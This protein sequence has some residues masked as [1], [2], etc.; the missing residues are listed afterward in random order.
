MSTMIDNGE[1]T[2]EHVDL[3]D[4]QGW[5]LRG[6]HMNAVRHIAVSV[7]RRDDAKRWI[8]GVVPDIQTAQAW[9]QPPETT[10]NLAFT[11]PGLDALGVDADTMQVFPTEFRDGMAS[12]AMK[13]GDS[14]LSAPEHWIEA[15]RDPDAVHMIVTVHA[16]DD[17][18]LDRAG[19]DLDQA[20]KAGTFRD[21]DRRTGHALPDDKVHFG[22]RDSI[23][24]PRFQ[25]LHPHHP[26]WDDQ[27]YAPLGVA[28]LGHPTSF[29]TLRWKVPPG[30][31]PNGTFNAYRI[32]QQDTVAFDAFLDRSAE[33]VL[34]H[35][36]VDA[37]LPMGAEAD[38]GPDVS[39]RDA[40]VELLAAKLLGRWRNGNSL[41]TNPHSPGE[42]LPVDQRSKFD[43]VDDRDGQVCPIGAHVRR[44][45]PRGATIVQRYATHTR[46]II[47]RGMPYGPTEPT[48]AG[49][50]GLL[51][52]FLCG[53]LGAQF[54]ALQN[55]WL[56]IGLL[57]PRITG[58]ND[59][60]L[61]ANDERTSRHTIAIGDDTIELHG[62]PRFVTTRGGAYTFIPGIAGLRALSA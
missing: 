50:R 41:I 38:Y 48:A 40:M 20:I 37:L 12:R 30:I 8:A 51:G 5:V 45:N 3:A 49:E 31:G 26:D 52:N 47:R 19:A 17:T 25:Q 42:L 54:E 14:A 16:A 10:L 43:Y 9:D 6:Y 4:V 39:R 55:D 33:R 61:G 22:F 59:P 7:Q 24:Q 28:L 60:V 56:N 32:L 1:S 35:P 29:E 44:N 57:D 62:F 58:T 53:D 36:L 27:P 21:V 23:S 46:R 18:G 15:Y 34:A 13:I 11:A 2:G